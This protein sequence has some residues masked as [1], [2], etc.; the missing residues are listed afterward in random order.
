MPAGKAPSIPQAREMRD[1]RERVAQVE[2]ARQVA[3]DDWEKIVCD[4]QFAPAFRRLDEV[5]EGSN[6]VRHMFQNVAAE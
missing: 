2:C 3:R 6:R 5:N 4:H 1:Q